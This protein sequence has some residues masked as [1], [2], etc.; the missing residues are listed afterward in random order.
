MSCVAVRGPCDL[1]PLPP[2]HAG[3]LSFQ[4]AERRPGPRPGSQVVFHSL[5]RLRPSPQARLTNWTSPCHRSR[6]MSTATV[7]DH[8]VS[9]DATAGS[10][11]ISSYEVDCGAVLRGSIS[12]LEVKRVSL[13]G[14][15]AESWLRDPIT[16][17]PGDPANRR[18]LATCTRSSWCR[19]RSRVGWTGTCPSPS[20][21]RTTPHGA[22]HGN[23]HHQAWQAQEAGGA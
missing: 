20:T 3:A 15:V 7:Y 16:P 9:S 13:G 14:S 8:T 10:G 2:C 17:A 12:P 21:P 1:A 11:S 19:R 5:T 6:T 18:R 23:V 4:T 22:G